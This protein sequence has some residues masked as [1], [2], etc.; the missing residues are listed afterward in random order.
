[1]LITNASRLGDFFVIFFLRAEDCAEGYFRM[2][3]EPLPK[4]RL[5]TSIDTNKK[6]NNI[7]THPASELRGEEIY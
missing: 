7:K 5:N 1:M 4:E 3:T 6:N 2:D